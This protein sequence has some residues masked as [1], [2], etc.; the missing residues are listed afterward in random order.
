MNMMDSRDYTS[1]LLPWTGLLLATKAQKVQDLEVMG[2][3]ELN[4]VLKS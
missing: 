1:I 4:Q 2:N 3:E